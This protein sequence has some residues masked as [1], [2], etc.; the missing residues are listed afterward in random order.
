GRRIL[1]AVMLERGKASADDVRERLKLPPH[2]GPVCLGA[3]PKPLSVAGIIRRAG[4]VTS[5]RP[6]AHAR[7]VSVWELV[8]AAAARQWIINHPSQVPDTEIML[9]QLS[10]FDGEGKS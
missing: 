3:V 9:Q 1:L 8:D 4:F 7:P 5:A 6:E 10:L 2:I